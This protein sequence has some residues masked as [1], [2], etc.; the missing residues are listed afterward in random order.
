MRI[1][2]LERPW[3]RCD[4]EASGSVEGNQT[5]CAFGGLTAGSPCGTSKRHI[6]AAS[7]YGKAVRRPTYV[8]LL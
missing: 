3:T 8:I 7:A 1:I 5:E 2:S 4:T 6:A